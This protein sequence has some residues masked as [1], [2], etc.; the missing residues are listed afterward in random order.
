MIEL[1]T[2]I[3]YLDRLA[4]DSIEAGRDSTGADIRAAAVDIKNLKEHVEELERVNSQMRVEVDSYK[5]SFGYDMTA[6]LCKFIDERIGVKLETDQLSEHIR[7][8][9]KDMINGGDI[10]VN[11]DYSRIDLDL[12]LEV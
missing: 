2:D 6:G 3:D 4:A 1:K 11:L 9:L 7:E 5:G 10:C 8:V 12:S